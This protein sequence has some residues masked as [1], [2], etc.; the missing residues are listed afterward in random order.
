MKNGWHTPEQLVMPLPLNK[1]TKDEIV[2]L[3]TVYF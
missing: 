2:V 1:V 3:V